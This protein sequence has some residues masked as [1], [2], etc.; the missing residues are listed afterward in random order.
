[1]QEGHFRYTADLVD[2]RLARGSTQPDIW[3]LVLSSEGSEA[4]PLGEMH[5]CAELFMLA[6]PETTGK[7]A[8]A[9]LI[10]EG[11]SFGT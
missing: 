5:S 6:G 4:L 2:S 7:L 10:Y 9:P 8:Q 3:N 1:M 11:R